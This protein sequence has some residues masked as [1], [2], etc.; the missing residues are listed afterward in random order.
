MMYPKDTAKRNPH[1]LDMAQGQPCL[2]RVPDVCNGNT[3][4]TVAAHSNQLTHGKGKARK[5]HDCYTVWSCA[6]CHSW[7]DQGYSA[8]KHQK[9]TAFN[10]A[11][12]RQIKEW[13]TI[14]MDER[15]KPKDR[16]AARW[17]L[18]ALE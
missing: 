15:E 8:T 4:T 13:T 6:R 3:S 12:K 5:A 2:M 14:A 9:V 16:A 18:G 11:H 1:L 17:A 7:L 10:E